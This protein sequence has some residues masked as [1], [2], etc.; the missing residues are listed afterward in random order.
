MWNGPIEVNIDDLF[1]ILGPNINVVSH[2]ESYIEESEAHIL[3]PYDGSNMF[4]IFEH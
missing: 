1:I 3:D 4:N 2:D